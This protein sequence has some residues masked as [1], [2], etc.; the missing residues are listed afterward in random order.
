M[1]RH[2]TLAVACALAL[3]LAAEQDCGVCGPGY[4]GPVLPLPAHTASLD[5]TVTLQGATGQAA[6]DC[7]AP[8]GSS[9]EE[10]TAPA[11]LN[12]ADAV[13]RDAPQPSGGGGQVSVA[14]EDGHTPDAT[15]MKSWLGGA[16]FALTVSCGGTQVTEQPDQ[17]IGRVC[18]GE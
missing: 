17:S 4:Q 9:V 8:S 13:Q 1:Q 14:F 5:C 16:D 11:G 10:C 2:P 6:F 15:T 12:V 18:V 3:L 7:P